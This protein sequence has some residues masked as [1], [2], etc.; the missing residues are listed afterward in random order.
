MAKLSADGASAVPED[1]ASDT[2]SS[3]F[4]FFFLGGRDIHYTCATITTSR[5]C[6]VHPKPERQK[7]TTHLEFAQAFILKGMAMKAKQATVKPKLVTQ[8]E[9]HAR[10]CPPTLHNTKLD[11]LNKAHEKRK[12]SIVKAKPTLSCKASMS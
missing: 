7:L 6:E 9:R 2:D 1:S 8:L 4:F 12:A 3:F 5:V 10:F 11:Q